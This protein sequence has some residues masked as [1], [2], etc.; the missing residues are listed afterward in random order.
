LK[1]NLGSGRGFSVLEVIEMCRQVTGH[2]IPARM[3]ERRP[4]DPPKLIA[5][6]SLAREVLDW[7]CEKSDLRTIVESA[8]SWH[9]SHPNGYDD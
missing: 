3:A 1:L 6:A 7:Q 5:D 2:P 8:W 9:R 4:G